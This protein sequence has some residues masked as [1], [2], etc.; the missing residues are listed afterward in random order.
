MPPFYDP[1]GVLIDWKDGPGWTTTSAL[2]G[3]LVTG[4]I[5]SGKSSGPGT[6]LLKAF[7]RSTTALPGGMGGVIFFAKNGECDE[8]ENMCRKHGRGQDVIRITADGRYGNF[9]WN[10]MDWIA[11]FGGA[12]A[13]TRGPIATVAYLEEV[14]SAVSP[15]G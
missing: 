7:L 9:V 14:A 11:Q 3:T 5:G 4:S 1:E 12:D 8:V 2:A 6:M 10:M 15:E 13:A